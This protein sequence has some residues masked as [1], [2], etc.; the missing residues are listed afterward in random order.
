M[1]TTFSLIDALCKYGFVDTKLLLLNLCKSFEKVLSIKCC[2]KIFKLYS[3]INNARFLTDLTSKSCVFLS[4]LIKVR[5]NV[6]KE[7]HKHYNT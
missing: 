2:Y 7:I 1:Q 5:Y 3:V 4:K 6:C